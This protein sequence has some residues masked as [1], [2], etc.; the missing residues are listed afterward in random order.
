[1]LV[2]AVVGAVVLARR[3]GQR[4]E[5]DEHERAIEEQITKAELSEGAEEGEE[6]VMTP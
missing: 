3:S 6:E 5:L 4:A 1:L 2:I